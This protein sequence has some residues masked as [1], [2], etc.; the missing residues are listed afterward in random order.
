[1]QRGHANSL[2]GVMA[3]LA[4]AFAVL[5]SAQGSCPGQA[6]PLNES[7]RV[8]V[9]VGP[10]AP[11]L[12]VYAGTQLCGYLNK[13]FGVKVQPT[14]RVPDSATAIFLIGNPT[15]N[16]TVRQ[17][18]IHD[19]FPK[20]D[21]QGIVLRRT[22]FKGHPA[23]LVGGGSP[24]ATLW[25][26]YELARR[27][28]VHYL[29]HGDVL[30]KGTTF[31]FPN[32][33]L[34]M[35]P[36]L[37]ERQFRLIDEFPM[38]PA[39]WGMEDF[40]PFI[41]QLAKLKFNRLLIVLWPFSPY[42]NYQVDGIHRSS[43][44]IFFGYHFPITPD[45]PGRQLF[46]NAKEFWN[47]DLP[48]DTSYQPFEAAGERLVHKLIA[49]GHER[50]MESILG[51]TP[52]QFP[53]EFAP[54]LKGGVKVHILGETVIAPGPTTN[55]D[56]PNLAKL[57]STVIQTAVNTYPE[58][59]GIDVG[60]PEFRQWT[61]VYKRAWRALDKK[62][63]IDKVCSLASVFNAAEHRETYPGGAKRAVD[64]VKGDIAALYFYDH[65]FDDLKILQHTRHPGIRLTIDGI[66]EELYPI[67]GRAVPPGSE[68]LNFV[69]YTP[70]RIVRRQQV[71][72]EVPDHSLP[73]LLI[74]TLN[75]DNIGPVPQLTTGSLYTLTQDLV[76]YGWAGFSTRYW[77][78]GDQDSNVS[79]LSRASWEARITPTRVARDQ[80][81][82]VCGEACVAPM[83]SA[84]HEVQEATIEL[85]W[86][87]LGFSFP[88]PGMMMKNWKATP[89][90][91]AY[92]TCRLDY[93][94][95]LDNVRRAKKA[96][97]GGSGADH[98][99]GY[100]EGRLEFAVEYFN[101]VDEVNRAAMAEAA[102]DHAETLQDTQ[103]ALDSSRNA[104]DAFARVARDQSDRG[105]I[106]MLDE[107]TYRPLKAKVNSLE[108]KARVLHP[109][110]DGR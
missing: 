91:A 64:E 15:T 21:D 53:L 3:I 54:L 33:N 63:G 66:A 65:L 5:L 109:N 104:I 69:D 74:Y 41:D 72:K 82:A 11:Q 58:A 28:G 32:V 51:L 61:G 37:R 48:M 73:S 81:Q 103:K 20:V 23:M 12:D 27:W 62:Y 89:L 45:M 76:R 13:L 85:E 93:R 102:G 106:A 78:I 47:P 59:D 2:D 79:Y 80:L 87:G 60:M 34:V 92:A 7:R 95:A 35:E 6:R 50:G 43:A 70:S 40:R 94:Q 9:I 88:V 25:A 110:K 99:L 52:T 105:A 107:Y 98:Y 100:W 39:S 68:V 44:G 18:T 42:L 57:A 10:E 101:A 56:D 8:V 71:L 26:V 77:N 17:A 22:A 108:N 38:G 55:I 49:Y 4:C 24:K 30:P 31:H 84:F 97:G 29:L 1:M 36:K 90:P 75:D 67:L 14:T 96:A 19:P 83:L 16:P 86:H 46:G